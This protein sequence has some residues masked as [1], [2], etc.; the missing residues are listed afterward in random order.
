[1]AGHFKKV[2]FILLYIISVPYLL[3]SQSDSLFTV[4][5]KLETEIV[6]QNTS[7]FWRENFQYAHQGDIYL[8]SVNQ[9]F[10]SNAIVPAKGV[11]QWKDEN[12][13]SLNVLRSYQ[14]DLKLGLFAESWYKNDRQRQSAIEYANHSTGIVSQLD[15]K[16][17]R[18]RPKIGYQYA[19]NIS[20]TDWGWDSGLSGTIHP[21]QF[22]EFVTSAQIESDYDF[23][24]NR[25]N[26]SNSF[27][28]GFSTEFNQYTKDSIDFV[29]QESKNQFYD[30]LGQN[31]IE[32]SRYQRGI[33]NNLYY[34]IASNKLFNIETKILSKN[35]NFFNNRNVFLV[36]NYFRYI[37]FGRKINFIADFK[38][39]SETIDNS[40]IVTDSE[41]LQSVLGLTL[42]Y[43]FDSGDDVKIRFNYVKLEYN[44]PDTV[45]NN[46]DRDEL[47]FV[48]N[49]V[50]TRN[51]SPVLNMQVLLYGY[52]FRQIFLFNEQSVNNNWNRVIKLEPKIRYN[53]KILKN[54]LLTNVITN[55]TEY[56]FE[57]FR[58]RSFIVRKY[59]LVD[60][61]T[62]RFDSKLSFNFWGRLEL[63]E[64]GSFF[65]Q[66]FSQNKVQEYQ[67]QYLNAHISYLFWR[68]IRT[69][70]GYSFFQRRE[71][72]FQPKKELN[73]VIKNQ[74]PFAGLS[75]AA[76]GD[77][78]LNAQVTQ[79]NL[80][81]TKN[82]NQKYLTGNLKLMYFF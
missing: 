61:L 77:V 15:F 28:I 5:P 32:V 76:S 56:D 69:F 24:E 13:F 43:V 27:Q 19:R 75:Y 74:G 34:N 68:R 10:F 51:F 21:F 20:V 65:K 73:R 38:T 26:Y 22:D 67:S 78:M 52:M 79:N 11:K 18:L 41:T 59:N 3:H 7:W 30:A 40:E 2:H 8:W 42:N 25:Q 70:I 64:K 17:L 29:Y 50:Y 47:R 60:S 45:N 57:D 62:Y 4:K 6:K 63:E 53:N 36:E 12:R 58:I 80:S 82:I 46:D 16:Y 48:L 9:N 49:T 72:R 66:S 39:S 37:Y 14:G 1:M 44:T 35:L 33:K 81:D 54:I 71:W 23:Y 55:I 31:I